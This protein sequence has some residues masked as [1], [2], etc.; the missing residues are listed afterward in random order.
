[1]NEK[2]SRVEAAKNSETES[3]SGRVDFSARRS[4][5]ARLENEGISG[6][7][8][9]RFKEARERMEAIEREKS[10]E[11]DIGL[12]NQLKDKVEDAAVGRRHL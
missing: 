6:D 11:R 7:V 10:S 3:R 1:M 12:R 5:N 9:N 8:R 4:G 2:M